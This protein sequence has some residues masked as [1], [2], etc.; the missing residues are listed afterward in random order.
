MTTLMTSTPRRGFVRAEGTRLVDDGGP[1]Q[2][3]G[4]GLGNWLLAEGYM[5]QFGDDMSSPRQIERRVA[6]L[7]GPERA[8]TF[9]R[10][11]RDSFITEADFAQISA[12]GFD[13]VRLPINA[14]GVIDDD[15]ELLEE[16]FAYIDRAV[17]WSERHGLRILLDLHGAPGGQTGT[18]IDDSP[19]GAP[20]LFT[21]PRYRALTV[22]LWQE[23]ARRYR[24]RESVLGYDL[25]NEPLPNEWQYR[26]HDELIDTYRELTAAI[27]EIDDRHLLMYE[28]SHWATNPAPV[29]VRYDENQAVQFHR[30][31]CPPDQ[32]S[33]ADF[34]ALRRDLGA[35]IYMGEGGENT[36]QWVYAATRLY[37]RHDI[38][39]NFWPWKKLNTLT[40]PLSARLPSGWGRSPI[41]SSARTRT[42]APPSS[43]SSSR[44]SR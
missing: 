20:E 17:A 3:R 35:P 31:W 28:G 38:G 16:G 1:V 42:R 13:H 43:R 6:E 21:S 15:G 41:P 14:R 37:E 11:F 8:A 5:W 18:N 32:T 22:R 25:L 27:R 12:A 19:R 30:Y 34:L 39:W 2:L 24:D 4:I 29:S 9:W 44:A 23:L 36:P 33:I 7:I 10:R 40:S 26:Y